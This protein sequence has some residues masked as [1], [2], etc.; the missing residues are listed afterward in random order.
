MVLFIGTIEN[1]IFLK[2]DMDDSNIL[3]EGNFAVAMGPFQ[4]KD[5]NASHLFRKQLQRTSTRSYII[6]V[7]KKRPMQTYQELNQKQTLYTKLTKQLKHKSILFPLATSF[8]WGK[9][10]IQVFPYMK[11]YIDSRYFYQLELQEYGGFNVESFLYNRRKPV[12]SMEQFLTIW[13]SVP[14]ILED[15]YHVLFDNHLIMTDIKIENMVLSH[16]YVLR[17]IDVDLNPNKKSLRVI[18]PFIQNLP[19]QYFHRQWWH[20]Q[21]QMTRK[22]LLEIYKQNKQKYLKNEKKMILSILEFIHHNRNPYSFIQEQKQSLTWEDNQFQRLFFVMYPLFMVILKMV[23]YQCVQPQTP[24]N[25]TRLN[26]IVAFCLETLRQRGHFNKT[27][28]Y[29]TFQDFL[30]N[31][32]TL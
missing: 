22:E 10:I 17:L 12:F 19:P 4:Y 9:H 8:V 2:K 29:H 13:R 11:Q 14:D 31:M 3:G 25:K 27:F 1:Y 28:N 20:P 6:K 16:D 26:K 21:D 24:E 23:V 5:V 30:W 18:T 32:K 15:S 7:Y